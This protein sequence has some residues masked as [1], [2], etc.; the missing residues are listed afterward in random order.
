MRLCDHQSLLHWSGT[1]LTIL[2]WPQP[3]FAD[4][5]TA[6]FTKTSR[7]ENCW[8]GPLDQAGCT[9]VSRDGLAEKAPRPEP[10]VAT[11]VARRAAPARGGAGDNHVGAVALLA[12]RRAT[13]AD[14][15]CPPVTIACARGW[16]T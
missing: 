6:L 3:A 16:A 15:A 8:H 7:D 1:M 2:A 11:E 5:L 4:V 9:A 10:S 13:E 12:S 14:A